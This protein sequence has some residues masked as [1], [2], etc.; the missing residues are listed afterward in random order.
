MKLLYIFNKL[1]P[2]DADISEFTKDDHHIYTT[3]TN[4]LHSP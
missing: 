1:S 4:T 2:A 3:Q